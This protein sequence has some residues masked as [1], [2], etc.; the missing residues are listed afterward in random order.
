MQEECVQSY[1]ASSPRLP[2]LLYQPLLHGYNR[3]P[4]NESQLLDCDKV[5]SSHALLANMLICKRQLLHLPVWRK[6]HRQDKTATA[7]LDET[8]EGGIH[9]LGLLASQPSSEW[10]K[11]THI[12]L[13]DPCTNGMQRSFWIPSQTVTHGANVSYWSN[14]PTKAKTHLNNGVHPSNRVDFT[15]AFRSH[16]V[17]H[18][19]RK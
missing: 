8:G 2:V 16:L 9:A 1:V 11:Y 17:W 19:F 15:V 18:W 5:S 4:K 3:Q 12:Q 10:K 7:R 14:R 13:W 6:V